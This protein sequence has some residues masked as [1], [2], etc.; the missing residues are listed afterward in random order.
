MVNNFRTYDLAVSF[1]NVCKKLS[2]PSFLRNQLDRASSSI[3]LNLAEGNARQ[4]R[5]DRKHFFNIAYGS[6]S[7]CKAILD[8]ATNNNDSKA[9]NLADNLGAHIYRLIQHAY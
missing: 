2:V 7:E 1:Y 6:L 9:I 4:M 5:N 3:V 8:I